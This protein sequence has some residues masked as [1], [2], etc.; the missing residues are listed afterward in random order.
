MT[1]TAPDTTAGTS[2]RP[3]AQRR[4]LTVLVC[5]QILSGAGLAA[6]IT[7][8]ALLAQ[9]MLGS[10]DL[11]G[12]PSASGAPEVVSLRGRSTPFVSSF[13]RA[14]PSSPRSATMS[15]APNTFGW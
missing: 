3:E 6:G 2:P 1:S 11:A 7:V 8:G 9:D 12:L 4:V 10:T 15:V 14:M 13:T 5:A